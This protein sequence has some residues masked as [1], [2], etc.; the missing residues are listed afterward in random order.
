MRS[1]IISLFA[2]TRFFCP[3]KGLCFCLSLLLLPRECSIQHTVHARSNHWELDRGEK[4]F[5]LQRRELCAFV[6]LPYVVD[7]PYKENS[8]KVLLREKRGTPPL[9]LGSAGER[10]LGGLSFHR[11]RDRSERCLCVAGSF[12]TF[13]LRR[14]AGSIVCLLPV[15]LFSPEEEK[16]E[17]IYGEVLHICRSPMHYSRTPEKGGIDMSSVVLHWEGRKKSVLSCVIA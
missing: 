4:I 5:G 11:E 9:Q 8:A 12:V 1:C 17:K 13:S 3:P 6:C 15:Q 14:R 7:R 16:T 10:A 2:D